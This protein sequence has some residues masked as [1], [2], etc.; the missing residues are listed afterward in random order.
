[1]SY[2]GI[3]ARF[4]F[5]DYNFVSTYLNINP[6]LRMPN[7]LSNFDNTLE[8][9]TQNIEKWLLR[10]SF[11]DLNL[12]PN[13]ILWR[14]KVA[15]S[16]GVSEKTRSWYQIIEEYLIDKESSNNNYIH[17]APICKESKY[18]R[19]LFC[20]YYGNNEFV[21]ETI[22]YFWLPKWCGNIKNPSARIL[23]LIEE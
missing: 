23:N 17:N 15:F 3:E 13:D 21:A 11:K 19:D 2:F 6:I 22:P 8:K 20:I 18:Y 14:K 9:S 5:L 10:E 12:L 16:D 1:M 4:P 7:N